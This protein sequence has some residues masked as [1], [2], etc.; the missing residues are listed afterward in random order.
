MSEE[1]VELAET[2]F[3]ALL[4]EDDHPVLTGRGLVVLLLARRSGLVL[5]RALGD[6]RIAFADE[7]RA[8]LADGHDHLTPFA[9][10]I[11][12]RAR[13][14]DRDRAPAGAVGDAEVE[15]GA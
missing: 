3:E 14:D 13:V 10:G 5:R 12:H 15:R 4:G 7:A 8:L 2:L 6:Q 9:E 1:N 11:G